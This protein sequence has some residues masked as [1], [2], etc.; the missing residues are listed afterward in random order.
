MWGKRMKYLVTA[1]EMKRYDSNTIE[2]TGIP[3]LVLMERAALAAFGEIER[4][5]A[6]NRLR[7]R[8]VLVL[9]G[10]G[11]NGGDGLALARLLAEAGYQ[12]EV[13][14]V[15][16]RDRACAQWKQQFA[17]LQ[18]YPV[19]TGSKPKREEYTIL[20]DALFGVGLSRKLEGEFALAVRK[21]NQLSGYK[22]ALDL[23]SGIN[24]DT[25]EVMGTAVK[26]DLTVVFGFLKRGLM[27]YP[28]CRFGGILKLF[29]AGINEYSFYGEDPGMFCYDETVSALLPP[30]EPEGNK[31]TF[32]KVL[33]VAGS[34]NM[35]GAAVLAAKGAYRMGAGMVKVITPPENRLIL[36]G[37]VPEA[38]LGTLEELEQALGWADVI[39]AGPGLSKG[40]QAKEALKKVISESRLPVILD[41]DCLNLLSES[42][43]LQKELSRQGK[44]GRKI[45]LTPHVGELSRLMNRSISQLKRDLPSAGLE[46]ARRIHAVVTAKDA[47]T[48]TCRESGPVCMNC[49]GSSAMATAG[50]GDVLTGMI[51]GLLAQG[52]EAFAAASVGVYIHGKAGEK[53]AG[54]LGEHGVM[55]GDIVEKA[56]FC[57]LT[58][59]KE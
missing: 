4:Y 15:G 48:Y 24:S 6:E 44:E 43:D 37:Q 58:E 21:F 27:M 32:G 14:C 52:M 16:D 42:Q 23:P 45:I 29:H 31:G 26:A 35:A 59:G 7:E 30:R 28:G 41:A 10:I 11:N 46:L 5:A 12:T 55:A 39:A 53:A 50:S 33:L 54:E 22:V 38:L 3:G 13:W 40:S 1:K 8:K 9:T 17:V 18:N 56:V 49:S 25:G 19:E 47:R 2:K 51:A 36:Q 20:I 34:L 57:R